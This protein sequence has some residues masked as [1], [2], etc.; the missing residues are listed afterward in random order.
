M[1]WDAL[2]AR[3]VAE[4]MYCGSGAL[5]AGAF[6]SHPLRSACCPAPNAGMLVSTVINE[7][8]SAGTFTGGFDWLMEAGGGIAAH[9]KVAA[10]AEN[11][12]DWAATIAL[13]LC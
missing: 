9:F 10:R 4:A 11:E 2:V 7:G 13:D 12:Q 3:I 6:Y 8:A 1:R 5:S